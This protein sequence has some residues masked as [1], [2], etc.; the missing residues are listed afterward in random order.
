MD[1]S[2]K[3]QRLKEKMR[4]AAKQSKQ[5]TLERLPDKAK[6]QSTK[7]VAAE[8]NKQIIITQINTVTKEDELALKVTFKLLPTKTAFSKLTSDLYFDDHKINSALISIPQSPLATNEFELTPMLDMKGIPVGP[9]IVR[10][11]M[12]ELWSTKERLCQTAKEVTV[13]YVPV[14]REERLVKVPIVKSVAGTDLAVVSE[15]EKDIYRE[16]EDTSKKELIS[17]RDEW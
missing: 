1:K 7:P 11:E 12:Y 10:M 6:N 3:N 15:L 16:I 9:H 4:T 2:T 5:T 14:T 8:Q 17:K 13:D